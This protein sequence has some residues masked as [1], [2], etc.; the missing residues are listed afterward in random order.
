MGGPF[1]VSAKPQL[2]DTSHHSLAPVLATLSSLLWR[3]KVISAATPSANLNTCPHTSTRNPCNFTTCQDLSIPFALPSEFQ[4]ESLS[5]TCPTSVP[6]KLHWIF[7]QV[8]RF[9]ICSSA[10]RPQLNQTT[11]SAREPTFYQFH[12]NVTR[13]AARLVCAQIY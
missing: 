1:P 7:P 11:S 9:E 12:L 6:G 8:G 10:D 2:R 13:T 4:R 3:Q 5:L